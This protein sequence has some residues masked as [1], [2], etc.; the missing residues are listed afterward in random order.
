MQLLSGF[1]DNTFGGNLDILKD[2]LV[3]VAANTLME[4]MGYFVPADIEIPLA[5]YFDR[6]LLAE[7]SE[8]G[9]ALATDANVVIYR[10]DSLFAP[11]SNMTRGDA[12]I[13]LD[14]VFSRVW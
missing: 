6:H 7:W 10:T 5:R 4:Q 1:T 12:A 3:V 14:R 13:I 8:D 11:L 9:I 2:Q